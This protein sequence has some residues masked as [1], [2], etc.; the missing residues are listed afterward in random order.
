MI[1][2]FCG[3]TASGSSSAHVF[4]AFSYSFANVANASRLRFQSE[5]LVRR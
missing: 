4:T 2:K 5:K 1:G 3:G